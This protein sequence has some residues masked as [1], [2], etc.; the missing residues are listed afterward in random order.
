LVQKS[1]ASAKTGEIEETPDRPS[2]AEKPAT[3]SSAIF[4]AL[5]ALGNPDASAVEVRDYVLKTWPHLRKVIEAEPHWNSYVTQGR[6]R[7]ARELGI[8]RSRR[9]GPRPGAA[10][11]I[12]STGGERLAIGDM[13]DLAKIRSKLKDEHDLFEV[14]ELILKLGPDTRLRKLLDKYAELVK[15]HNDDAGKAE[16]FLLQAQQLGLN[17]DV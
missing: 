12:G 10:L 8:E 13:L 15:R 17:W 3:K 6:D 9:R 2:N 11:S 1:N 4:Q 5:L 7:A 14:V 16:E